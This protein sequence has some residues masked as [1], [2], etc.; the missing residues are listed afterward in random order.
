MDGT[1]SNYAILV[2]IVLRQFFILYNVMLRSKMRGNTQ[3]VRFAFLLAF[4]ELI[5]EKKLYHLNLI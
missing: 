1:L 3:K 5:E 2:L 4:H